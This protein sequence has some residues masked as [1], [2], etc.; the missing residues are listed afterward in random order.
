M[1]QAIKIAIENGY[2]HEEYDLDE[3]MKHLKRWKPE[4]SAILIDPLFWQALG[5]GLWWEKKHT[6]N[7]EDGYDN[8]W[9]CF[10]HRFI[11]HIAEGKDIDSFFANLLK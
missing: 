7:V 9:E 3:C 11:D 8:C 6:H 5:K 2:E 1:E 4:I 10:W